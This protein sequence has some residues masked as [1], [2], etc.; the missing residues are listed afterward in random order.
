MSAEDRPLPPKRCMC[1][2]LGKGNAKYFKLN[3]NLFLYIPL[4]FLCRILQMSNFSGIN[5]GV[6]GKSLLL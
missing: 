1:Y 3:I 5:K 2:L 6:W 4:L